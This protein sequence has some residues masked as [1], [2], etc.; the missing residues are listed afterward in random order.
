M[1]A[2]PPSDLASTP[3]RGDHRDVAP[4]ITTPR[5]LNIPN[6]ITLSRLGLAVIVLLLI[7]RAESWVL[8]TIIFVFAVF[9]DV[10]DGYLARR[11]N[12]V[13]TLGRILDPFV[14]KMIIGGAL[15]F[16]VARP[17]SGVTPWLTFIVIGR[18]MFIT[19]LR[20]VLE[21]HGVDFSAKLSGKLKMV[22]QSAT[23][24]LCMLSLSPALQ[25]SWAGQWEL[26]LTARQV[27][28]W[29]TLL[30]TLYS[31]AEYVWRG[32]L[33]MRGRRDPLT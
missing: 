3:P 19:G 32:Y 5:S 33:L 23:I 13:T 18:E 16:L 24:P 10:I 22:L 31:G 20:S 14:D 21:A 25:R 8:T 15:I 28:L 4:E 11:W 2:P 6:L 17:E 12:Q 26:F 29:A 1:T 30:I 27:C 7:E 9:T